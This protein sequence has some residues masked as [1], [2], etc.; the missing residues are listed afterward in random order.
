[1][2]AA[3]DDR[4][5]RGCV[6]TSHGWG[7]LPGSAERPQDGIC[8]NLLI[9]DAVNYEAINAMPH[10]SGVPVDVVALPNGSIG[11]TALT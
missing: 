10:F 9:D 1:M 8:V 6:Q 3:R 7:E 11:S 5:R 2:I 4:V